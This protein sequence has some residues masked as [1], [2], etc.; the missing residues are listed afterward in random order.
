[1]AGSLIWSEDLA[2]GHPRI[3]AEHRR[4][5][6]LAADLESALGTGDMAA[7]RAASH[8]FV[9]L[10]SAHCAYEE[11]LMRRLPHDTFGQRVDDHSQRHG[12]LIGQAEGLADLLDGDNPPQDLLSRS[13]AVMSTVLH[14]LIF[15]D[16]NL[17]G[18]L[19]RGDDGGHAVDAATP[20][21][22][23]GRER[24]VAFHLGIILAFVLL[25]LSILV[26]Y[27]IDA[28][29]E[30]ALN[31]IR[32]T[33]RGLSRAA[34][35]EVGV[36][37]QGNRDALAHMAERPLIRGATLDRCD[38]LLTDFR[39]VFPRF[40]NVAVV[41]DQGIAICSAVAQ[42]GGKP[43]DVFKTE[44]FQRVLTEKTFVVGK[45]F[46]GPITGRWVSVLALP[47]LDDA[48]EVSRVLG[49]PLDLVN[50]VPSAALAPTIPNT[51]VGILTGDG[52]V[53]WRNA[54]PEH[55]VGKSVADR[56]AFRAFADQGQQEV[57]AASVDDIE[58]VFFFQPIAS[59]DWVAFVAVPTSAVTAV[60]NRALAA[61]LSLG[62][63]GF[64]VV[65]AIAVLLARRLAAPIRGLAD[66]AR[67]IREGATGIRAPVA[68][69]REV[70]EVA[71]EFNALVETRERQ[72]DALLRSN[73]EL[74]RFAYIAAHDLQE[75]V[76]TVVAFAQML[77]QRHADAL[78]SEGRQLLH[79]VVQGAKRM[80]ELVRD[81]LS[82]SSID[83][84]NTAC[85]AV[86]MRQ[87]VAVALADLRPSI[88]ENGA[89]IDVDT[90]SL[91]TVYGDHIQIKELL[92]HLLA[93][94][95]RFHRPGI[96]PVVRIGAAPVDGQP[97]FRVADN[98]IGIEDQYWQQIFVIFKRL[99][100]PE[101]PGTGVGLA[102]CKRV[103]E[104]HGGRIWVESVPGHGSTFFFTLGRS[105]P[106]PPQA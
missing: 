79:Y 92:R 86:D 14:D 70:A 78:G 104:R 66:T 34:A 2:L 51:L 32:T 36:S 67:K 105:S 72:T 15:D 77:D 95:I 56:P 37:F 4:L 22:S 1:M 52:T 44:W 99:H 91:P 89:T 63:A 49:L 17:V 40:A 93:N 65:T 42:P 102:L 75:P 58:R 88:E 18:T 101:F 68:G 74:E 19:V 76:R 81:L 84:G 46:I 54:D 69:P 61:G 8:E 98:G 59:S 47:I 97:V 5:V 73:A 31:E 28:S 50:Y 64:L 3:D 23:P 35:A 57:T 13:T 106:T 6:D 21:P 20:L 33:A 82:Y 48:G 62:G 60:R 85:A 27:A 12:L 16:R 10:L 30:I 71:D 90:P 38:P 100:G 43:V 7:A 55:W 41:D 53:V 94:A 96:A 103:V 9:A 29:T 26:A 39:Q 11:R 24:S 87:A 80:H 25:S 45:P 83:A